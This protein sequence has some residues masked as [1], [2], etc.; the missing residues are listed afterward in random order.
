M[1]K[2]K[3]FWSLATVSYTSWAT[4]CLLKPNLTPNIQIDSFW[5]NMLHIP[6][7][8]IM[9]GLIHHA[10]RQFSMNK[11]WLSG[12]GVLFY[13]GAIE[14]IQPHFGR[15]GDWGDMGLNLV[16]ICLALGLYKLLSKSWILK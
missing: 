10:I 3:F 6:A 14:L 13:S 7:Y 5:I 1:D 4:Y 15:Q 16:G 8:G 9:V 11:Y 12:F 2:N